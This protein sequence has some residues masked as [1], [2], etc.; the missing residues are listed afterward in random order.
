[1]W[2]CTLHKTEIWCHLIPL[3][4]RIEKEHFS[5][6]LRWEPQAGR[7]FTSG[8]V[9]Y[10]YEDGALQVNETALYHVYSRVELTFKDCDPKSSFIHSVFVRRAGRPSPM[11]LMEAHRAGFCPQQHRL[12]W[13]TESY[14]GSALQ[15][16]KDDR[17]YVNISE[18]KSLSHDHYANFFG[19]YKVWRVGEH[20]GFFV[21]V[22]VY[23][24]VSLF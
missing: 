2:F 6:T 15:L 1:M 23:P 8:G 20:R 17:V 13:T 22:F 7:A 9:A 21:C 16:Q 19:L 3:A 5:K 12:S 18:P 24:C 14:L 11:T 4:G 10:R